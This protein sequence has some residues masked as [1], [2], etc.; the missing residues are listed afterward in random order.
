MYSLVAPILYREVVV[1]DL[2]RFLRGI[3]D[4]PKDDLAVDFDESAVPQH[5]SQLLSKT[6]K[7]YL[8]PSSTREFVRPRLVLT[9]KAYEFPSGELCEVD[10]LGR[11]DLD[12][13]QEANRLLDD[14]KTR[15]KDADWIF[16]NLESVSFGVWTGKRWGGYYASE[17]TPYRTHGSLPINDP[18]TRSVL[19]E[20]TRSWSV[21]RNIDMC[22]TLGQGI[23]SVF[24]P[25]A[26]SDILSQSG[27]RVIHNGTFS[28]LRYIY[29]YPGP[30]RIYLGTDWLEAYRNSLSVRSD[31]REPFRSYGW[32][33]YLSAPRRNWSDER[34]AAF[35]RSSMVLCIVP[36]GFGDRKAQD[37]LSREVKEA[38][39]LFHQE[40]CKTK[41]DARLWKDRIKILVGEEVPACPCCGSKS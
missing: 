3:E 40:A 38:L 25:V 31:S 34:I 20:A 18:D 29:N 39:E 36:R 35:K 22:V 1:Q 7:L 2:G 10:A 13:M 17:P 19:D 37:S 27:M 11:S 30:T 23:F 4:V 41:G 24:P 15:N 6:R 9:N 5:K 12:G 8:I 26:D 33:M 21:F 16:R 32:A 28:T 14:Y